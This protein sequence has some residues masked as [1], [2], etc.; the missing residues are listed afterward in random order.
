MSNGGMGKMM[1]Q[2]QKAQAEMVRLQEGL[3]R[4]TVQGNSGGGA[5]QV[6][7]NGR[8]ELLAIVIDPEVLTEDNRDMLEDLLLT[9]IN[10]ALKE[11]DEMINAEMHKLTGGINLPPG[12]I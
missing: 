8:K 5:V 3:A 10:G 6:T 4:R 2:L 1:K 12:L 7:A 11:V 9:A